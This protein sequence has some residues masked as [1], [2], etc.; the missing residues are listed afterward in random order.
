[1]NQY[2]PWTPEEDA[3]LAELY[4]HYRTA[5]VAEVLGRTLM[6][7]YQRTNF[8]GL[9]KHVNGNRKNLPAIPERYRVAP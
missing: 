4:P 3:K 9:R 6:A 5:E 1:M 8:L 7:T 2:R